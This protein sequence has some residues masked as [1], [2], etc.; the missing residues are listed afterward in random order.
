VHEV[1]AVGCMSEHCCGCGKVI[2]DA[3]KEYPDWAGHMWCWDC[4][5]ANWPDE[6]KS[7]RE[8]GA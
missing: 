1:R 3:P 4:G 8:V 5:M 2:A 7:G 6:P